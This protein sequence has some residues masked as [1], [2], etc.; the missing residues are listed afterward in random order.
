MVASQQSLFS[1]LVFWFLCAAFGANAQPERFVN[2][3]IDPPKGIL[4]Y[5]PPGT[6][7]TVCAPG[8]S[9]RCYFA[10]PG[11]VSAHSHNSLCVCLSLCA[12]VCVCVCLSVC[13]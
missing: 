1:L 4:L 10:H 12:C 13:V 7:K 6:G 3:G 11:L 9:S 2:L 8:A 5:G